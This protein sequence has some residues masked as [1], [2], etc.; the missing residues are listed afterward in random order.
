MVEQ[1]DGMSMHGFQWRWVI[2]VLCINGVTEDKSSWVNSEVNRDILSAQIQSNGTKLI[3]RHCIVQMDDDTKHTAK[4]TQEFL[5]VKKVE[6]SEMAKSVPWSQQDLTWISLA[7][8][9]T[10]GRKTHKQTTDVS[11]SK[12]LAFYALFLFNCLN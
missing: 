11:C 7:E 4:A 5:M 8:D 2:G 3:G 1:C 9:K 10:K 6:Y 12:G